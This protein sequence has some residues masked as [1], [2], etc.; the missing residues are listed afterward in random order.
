LSGRL[1]QSSMTA[2]QTDDGTLEIVRYM[3]PHLIV[4]LLDT[5]ETSALSGSTCILTYK[6]EDVYK[7]AG[8]LTSKG[9]KVRII[10]KDDKFKLRDLVEVV[11]FREE[12]NVGNA[13]NII[14]DDN[15][16]NAKQSLKRKYG[17]S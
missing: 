11:F 12:L 8:A 6:N 10:G 13:E 15:W 16:N 5:I 3:H 17:E 2:S 4:S 14:T 7:I 9:K 1:R